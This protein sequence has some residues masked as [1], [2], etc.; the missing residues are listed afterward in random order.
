MKRLAIVALALAGALTA[1]GIAVAV[2]TS[3]GTNL[4]S[5]TFS[6]TSV[7]RY[8]SR[9]CTGADGQYDVVDAIYRGAASSSEPSLSGNVRIRI[10]SAYN[11]TKNIGWANGWFSF[12]GSDRGALGFDAVEVNGKL[13]GF[14]R[15]RVGHPAAALLGTFTSDYSKS[16]GFANGQIGGGGSAPNV[17]VIA[18][19]LCS[20][21]TGKSVKLT[22]RGIVDSLTT[23][24]ISVKPDDGSALQTCAIAPSSPST[25]HVAKGDRV[26]MSCAT[27]NGTLTLTKLKKRG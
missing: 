19:K 13:T 4:V 16:G 3:S 1:A 10:R 26:E 8:N 24:S 6:A 2:M 12:S 11:T 17:D 9:T 7:E 23:T 18:N 27:V 20:G 21:N 22:V 25:A 5:A 15:G 14:I